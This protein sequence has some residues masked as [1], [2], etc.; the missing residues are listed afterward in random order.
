LHILH[1]CVHIFSERDFR[2]FQKAVRICMRYK[3]RSA[4][5]SCLSAQINTLVNVTTSPS[6]FLV[7]IR[8]SFGMVI[9]VTNSFH[10]I[11]VIA[12]RIFD[13]IISAMLNTVTGYHID[14]IFNKISAIVFPANS[15]SV[16]HLHA[17]SGHCRHRNGRNEE[18]N[19]QNRR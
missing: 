14:V 18:K 7:H 12:C 10:M 11:E 5:I 1:Y 6:W 8:E 15:Q 3:Y 16:A 13:A 9:H 2:R 4:R 17:S 19:R